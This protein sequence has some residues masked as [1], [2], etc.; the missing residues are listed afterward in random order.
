MPHFD[1]KNRITPLTGLRRGQEGGSLLLEQPFST[2]TTNFGPQS[3]IVHLDPYGTIRFQALF[4]E[5][6]RTASFSLI[7]GVG[8]RRGAG[9]VDKQFL[10]ALE[11]T[12]NGT[13]YP[14]DSLV[15]FE[16]STLHL[17][18]SFQIPC[19]RDPTVHLTLFGRKILTLQYDSEASIWR[20]S[21]QSKVLYSFDYRN[22]QNDTNYSDRWQSVSPTKSYRPILDLHTHFTAQIGAKA[23]VRAGLRV[24]T[25][26]P[27]SLLEALDIPYRKQKVARIDDSETIGLRDLFAELEATGKAG[28]MARF[29]AALCID[30]D[31]QVNFHETERCY[32]FRNPMAKDLNAFPELLL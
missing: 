2:E 29:L 32:E 22:L 12:V 4:D 14:V 26:Y 5:Y 11:V 17:N 21:S 8:E 20:K 16:R 27:V 23:L 19:E 6:R 15:S 10:S 25:P 24:N 1:D 13:P 3:A 7:G 28:L 9:S 18:P 31:K 30:S